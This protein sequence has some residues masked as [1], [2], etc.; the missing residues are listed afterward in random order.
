M[1]HPIVFEIKKTARHVQRRFEFLG[2]GWVVPACRNGFQKEGSPQALAQNPHAVNS[3]G[4]AT[5]GDGLSREQAETKHF[6]LKTEAQQW[7]H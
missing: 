3:C 5:A 4:E 2:G 6:N 7:R 1:R